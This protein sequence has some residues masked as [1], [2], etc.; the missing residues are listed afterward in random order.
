MGSKEFKALEKR[1]L[2]LNQII[3]EC[4]E[5]DFFDRALIE[6]AFLKALSREIEAYMKKEKDYGSAAD[7][8]RKTRGI[9][10]N[11]C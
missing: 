1:R 11:L 10:I 7:N 3:D 4:E 5:Q 6:V 8:V 2:R 9:R